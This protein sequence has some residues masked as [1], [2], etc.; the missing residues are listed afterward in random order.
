MRRPLRLFALP[1]VAM[2]VVGA[3]AGSDQAEGERCDLG[4]GNSDCQAGL[5]CKSLQSLHYPGTSA[6][7]CPP[8]PTTAVCLGQGASLPED[9]GVVTG[10][11]GGASTGGASGGSSDASSG[12]TPSTDAGS[13][14]DH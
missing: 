2:A 7:C 4:N 1:L 10:S 6:V 11:G 12:G 14:R 13:H 9:G 5:V 8:S 3:S